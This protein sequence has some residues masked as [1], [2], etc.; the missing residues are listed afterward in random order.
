M[1]RRDFLQKAIT[2][3]ALPLFINGFPIQ[4]LADNPIVQYL[5]K[6]GAEDHVLVLIQFEQILQKDYKDTE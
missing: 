6:A 2:A 3:S 4:T 5:G 1:K